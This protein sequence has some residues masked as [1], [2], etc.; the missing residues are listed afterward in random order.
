MFLRNVKFMMQCTKEDS[1]GRV[2]NPW[3]VGQKT[4]FYC[5]GY[6]FPLPSHFLPSG[7]LRLH[8]W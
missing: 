1:G 6:I 7:F 5:A 3:I 8:K 2:V 4:N